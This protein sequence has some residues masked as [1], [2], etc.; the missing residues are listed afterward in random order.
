M[1]GGSR[2]SRSSRWGKYLETQGKLARIEQDG[3]WIQTEDQLFLSF[4]QMNSQPSATW[5]D[6]ALHWWQE[7]GAAALWASGIFWTVLL[8][9]WTSKLK[10]LDDPWSCSL[11][12]S[13]VDHFALK[14]A[15][16]IYCS[17]FNETLY[18][19][20][21]WWNRYRLWNIPSCFSSEAISHKMFKA[22][23]EVKTI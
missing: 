22:A 19:G 14:P 15:E 9:Y 8:C 5:V 1:S 7:A 16:L 2:R 3:I 6:E 20:S 10:V 18:R 11:S 23:G 4:M 12:S 13:S 21:F 17:T